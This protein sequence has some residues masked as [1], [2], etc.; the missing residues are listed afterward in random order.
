MSCQPNNDLT[1]FILS[2]SL[3]D[4]KN[5]KTFGLLRI[6]GL[7]KTEFIPTLKEHLKNEQSYEERI[8]LERSIALLEKGY[9]NE[10]NGHLTIKNENGYSF[11][12]I[13]NFNPIKFI[14]KLF[15]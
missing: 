15:H 12:R 5:I 2:E 6:V 9:F 10:E 11:E 4:T 3:N 1:N 8:E 13:E 7:K 14:K